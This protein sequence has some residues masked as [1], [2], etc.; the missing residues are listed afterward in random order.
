MREW[1]DLFETRTEQTP[2]WINTRT[3]QIIEVQSDE[4]ESEAH[5]NPFLLAHHAEFGLSDADVAP[6]RDLPYE[7]MINST[8][9]R[10]KALM[11][12]WTRCLTSYERGKW[13]VQIEARNMRTLY[14]SA[15][16]LMD[17]GVSFIKG[18]ASFFYDLLQPSRSGHLDGLRL[19]DFIASGKF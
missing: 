11:K 2:L 9:L 1:I 13:F 12:G 10:E 14:A 4:D 8:E 7:N 5:H 6:F 16:L 19:D 15:L 18:Q 17:R 3:K